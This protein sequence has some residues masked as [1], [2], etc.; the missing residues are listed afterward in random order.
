MVDY[1]AIKRATGTTVMEDFRSAPYWKLVLAGS[2]WGIVIH[3]SCAVGH[4]ISHLS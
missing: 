1:K 4:W 2:A 3:L